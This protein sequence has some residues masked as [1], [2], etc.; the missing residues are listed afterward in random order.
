MQV[1]A[2]STLAGFELKTSSKNS[3]KT[4]IKFSG[5]SHFKSSKNCVLGVLALH[6]HCSDIV[7]GIRCSLTI[8]LRIKKKINGSDG[9]GLFFNFFLIF[10]L[11]ES[12]IFQLVTSIEQFQYFL[13]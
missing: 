3:N 4:I 2:K 11:T 13:I 8:T 10:I 9:Q 7:Y 6:I 12:V 1:A 5:S